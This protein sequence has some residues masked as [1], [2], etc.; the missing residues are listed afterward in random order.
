MDGARIAYLRTAGKLS[1]RDLAKA[2]GVAGTVLR[3]LEAGAS[4]CS[5]HT[6]GAVARALGVT[7]ESLLRTN[8]AWVSAR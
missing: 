1:F 8:P 3:T 6:I 5:V 4:D 2:S 7:V